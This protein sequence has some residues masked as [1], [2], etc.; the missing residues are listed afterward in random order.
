[1]SDDE[2]QQSSSGSEP[3][4]PVEALATGRAKRSTAGNLL[5]GLL[6]NLDEDEELR[7]ELLEDEPDDVG[8]YTGSDREDD[9]DA[10]DSSSDDEDAQAGKEDEDEG[11][12]KLRQEERV[13]QRK[14]RKATKPIVPAFR[15]R[16]KLDVPASNTE[17]KEGSMPPP[18]R[19]K[20]KS[21]RS[22][23]LPTPADAPTRQSSRSLAV[24]NREVVTASLYESKER[25][26]KQKE[27]MARAAAKKEADKRPDLT[28]AD[29]MA[30]AMRIEKENARSLNRWEMAERERERERKEKLEA[31]RN[32]KLDGPVI[33]QWSGS[34]IWEGENIK[35]KRVAGS[36]IVDYFK[37]E[38][39]VP[40]GD[41]QS[42]NGGSAAE[43]KAT[44]LE[45]P[46]V[47]SEPVVALPDR[48]TAPSAAPMSAADPMQPTATVTAPTATVGNAGVHSDLNQ[49][50]PH[51]PPATHHSFT[52][53]S[54]AGGPSV[55]Q[56]QSQPPVPWLAGIHEYAAQPPTHLQHTNGPQSQPLS[57]PLIS[58]F[59]VPA[60]PV[61]DQPGIHPM[62]SIMEQQ[63]RSAGY[64][65][66]PPNTQQQPTV[67]PPIPLI[68]EQ[69]Q[70]SLLILD[71]FSTLENLPKYGHTARARAMTAILT[72]DSHPTLTA[73]QTTYITARSSKHK[74]RENLLPEQPKRMA[75]AITSR[76]ARYRDPKTGL[77]YVDVNAYKDIQK[78]LAGRC[79]WSGLLGA[80][81]GPVYTILY[82]RPARGV[83]EGFAGEATAGGADVK[84]E[85]GIS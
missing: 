3:S 21:E 85:E 1:M 14:K 56:V 45:K 51:Q 27:L 55:Q 20:K 31:L 15:K 7:K 82:G 64:S 5:R 75:C 66:P 42:Q 59:S 17:A 77:G 73:A 46:G 78:I 39:K 24:A 83:P 30:R 23:W 41:K 71:S 69:A 18:P 4:S 6:D 65:W 67:G 74:T 60:A 12:K 26:E 25:S 34:V 28:Q 11:E 61:N 35:V 40:N 76:T 38:N 9:D 10:L 68:R 43:I 80:W 49:Q 8:E 36:K 33:R 52:Q 72:P 13:E 22:S 19:P 47:P 50:F 29:R 70:R 63:A 48:S 58:N 37:D 62:P 2:D 84:R 57:T 79:Q 81:V 16:V 44:D 53:Q 54:A 32:K